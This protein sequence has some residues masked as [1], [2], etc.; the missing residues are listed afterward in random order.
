V[1]GLG[2]EVILVSFDRWWQTFEDRSY[3]GVEGMF[4]HA[5]DDEHVIAGNATIGLEIVEDL[6]EVET[7]L[8][9]W[10]GG[11]LSTGIAA[12][13][14][15][16][17]PAARVFAVEVEGAAPLAAALRAGRPEAIDYRPSFVDGIGSKTVM[18]NMLEQAQRLLAGSLTATVEE[19]AAAV[20]LLAE[21]ARVVAEGA[22]AAAV[23]VAL[24][25]RAGR[26][27]IACV[28]SG[29]NIDLHKLAAIL[30]GGAP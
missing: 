25:G 14:R 13:V 20:R 4:V 1:R 5:F 9:P 19:V 17:K 26:G 29:G 3:P 16:M 12:A 30:E 2:A 15:A 6:P 22:G 27:P 11:G 10:G 24:S 23:A 18:P 21:R 8:V 7:V 28:V